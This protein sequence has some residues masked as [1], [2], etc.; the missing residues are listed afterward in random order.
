MVFIYKIYIIWPN[1][2]H[3]EQ[4]AILAINTAVNTDNWMKDDSAQDNSSL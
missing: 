3:C 4:P 2:V 1:T